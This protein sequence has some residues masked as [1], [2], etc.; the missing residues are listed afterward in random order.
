MRNRIVSALSDGIFVI[1]AQ[2]HSG[3][4]ITVDFGLEQGKEIYAL[5][6]NIDSYYNEGCNLLIKHGAKV[7]TNY[8]DILEDFT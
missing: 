6:G 3:A 1:Q 2:K 4:M 5:P 7:V 8:E